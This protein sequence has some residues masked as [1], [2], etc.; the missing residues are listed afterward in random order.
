MVETL[1][2]AQV[3][4]VLGCHIHT[5][6]R[7]IARKILPAFY[8]GAAVRIAKADVVGFR[9]LHRWQDGWNRNRQR[10]ADGKR[11]TSDEP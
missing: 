9:K 2:R 5:I 4:E 11:S 1:T 10:K 7:L 6:D 3:A 8:V